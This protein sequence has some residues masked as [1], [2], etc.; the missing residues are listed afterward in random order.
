MRNF[1]IQPSNSYTVPQNI[2]PAHLFPF[3]LDPFQLDSI[4]VLDQGHSLVVSA[5][6]GSGKTLVAEYAIYRALHHNQRVF[7]TTPLKALSNQKLRDFR[8]KFGYEQVGLMTGDITL[9]RNARIVVMTTEIF[10]NMVY[11]KSSEKDD[12]L[13]NVET[14]VLD[15]CHY[16]ND[17]QRG[18]VWEESIIHCPPNIQLVALSAT[19][20]NPGQ[21]TDWIDRVHGPT[22]LIM[23][24]YRPVDL[25]FSFCSNKGLHLL[26][27]KEISKRNFKVQAR[28]KNR[29]IQNKFKRS[30]GKIL[31]AEIPQ[32]DFVLFQMAEHNMLPTIYFIFSRRNCDKA[33]RELQEVTLVTESERIRIKNH[34]SLYALNNSG[35]IR[36]EYHID[37]LKRGIAA[38]HA[39][40]LPP[41][42]ELIERLF[43]EGLIKV[44][45]A[46]ETLA[47]GI[48]MP[49]RSTVIS[50]L[51]KRTEGGHRS[52]QSNEFLQMAGR[53]GRRGLDKR[54]Y[55]II[56]QNHLE[57]IS[58]AIQFVSSDADPLTS[59]FI[60]TYSMV[61]N[62]ME[63]NNLNQAKEL[64]ERSFAHYLV[65]LKF[66]ERQTVIN[67]L[68]T[69]LDNLNQRVIDFPCKEPKTY[70]KLINHWQKE[71]QLLSTCQ[72]Q[73]SKNSKDILLMALDL[74]REGTL[75]NVQITNLENRILPALFV[76]KVNIQ[77][78]LPLILCLTYQNIWALLP[79][80][81]IV[82]LHTEIA[83]L[84]LRNIEVPSMK[85]SGELITGDSRSMGLALAIAYTV[86]Y[87]EIFNKTS[88][89][90]VETQPQP[91][92]IDRPNEKFE[93]EFLKDPQDRKQLNKHKAESQRLKSE[94]N[95]QELAL[96]Y[97]TR[98]HWDTFLSMLEVLQHFGC[99]HN[100]KP[101]K[102]GQ[103]IGLI[104]GDNELWLGLILVSGHLDNLLPSDLVAIA[105]SISIEIKR[106]DVSCTYQVS[107]QADKVFYDISK[108]RSELLQAQQLSNI[109][110]PIWWQP[111][112][113]SLVQAWSNGASWDD[114][115]SNT[116]ID[117]GDIVRIIRRTIDFLAQI[118]HC[119]IISEKLRINALAALE[120]IHRF[121]ISELE[122]LLDNAK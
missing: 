2:L 96:K 89:I 6:T 63:Y 43:Q 75:I 78:Q 8:E 71:K 68:K 107:L 35:A 48:N 91:K 85:D 22:T 38:H 116:S 119:P 100:L 9:N 4:D 102:I 28:E 17:T 111:E 86:N 115:I 83:Y 94:I 1:R 84:K 53:A 106:P 120:T 109:L 74:L 21:L 79:F 31:R 24:D 66:V 92:L 10:R 88:N 105:E 50:S 114:L 40:L 118:P 104:R 27:V 58:D 16:I 42:K 15:E 95:H 52:L 99:I 18:T 39:G 30:N 19:I 112:L 51:S 110:I 80:N 26:K 57:G 5:P 20:A 13:K 70:E 55:V 90:E 32:T 11:T 65:N 62:L 67:R 41:W 87:S 113:M 36:D 23:S 33:V 73:S 61:I 81:S 47:A 117:E 3:P 77:S 108:I 69:Q 82:Q 46:T 29:K 12:P 54:G 14:I 76:K 93:K 56:M 59:Q 72:G 37:A 64:I 103:T 101:T 44:V 97:Q 25:Q 34:L 60:P 49:A 7:Y 122:V 45:F 98:S 121:P